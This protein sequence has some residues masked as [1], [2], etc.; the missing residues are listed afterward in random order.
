MTTIID[1]FCGAGGSSTGLHAAGFEVVAAANHWQL[2]IETHNTNHPN[3]EHFLDDLQDIRYWEYFD[4]WLTDMHNLGYHSRLLYLNAQFFGVPQSRDRFYAVFWRK[5]NRAP[6]L[7]F[8]PLAQCDRHGTVKA[9]QA[10]KKSEFPWG[11]YGE[12]RQYQ[13]RCPHCGAVVKPEHVPA[14]SVI[15]WSLTAPRIGDRERPLKPRTMERIRAGLKKF[16]RVAHVAD[17]GHMH[18]EH[19]GKVTLVESVLPT[20]STQQTLSLVEPFLTAQHDG[21][22]P[23]RSL[24]DPLW[25]V[26]GM[27]NEQQ[28]VVPPFLA[29]MKNSSADGYN[30][31]CLSVDDPLSTIVATASQHALVMSYYGDSPTF[32]PVSQPLPTMRTVEHEAL[33]EVTDDLVDS[34][35]FR[36]LEPHELKRGMSFPDQ[37]VILGTKKDQVR[38]IGNAVCCHV[39][40][41]I[42]EQVLA[43]LA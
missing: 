4:Q 31:P 37:Y 35:G 10:F 32:A 36:M 20:Q 11:R 41:W 25:A 3:T 9:V 29:V 1:F 14:A 28:L 38:Q 40:Q 42:G 15:D 17:L 30:Q 33:I 22:N 19:P 27:N 13:Y 39:A 6:S 24:T 34:C 2:A 16:G 12:R 7:D 8:R 18:A 5:G 43:S 23:L 26:T 21:R